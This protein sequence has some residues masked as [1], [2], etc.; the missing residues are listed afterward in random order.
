MVARGTGQNPICYS[1]QWR[2]LLK[3][4][5]WRKWLFCQVINGMGRI[6]W[7]K[8]CP[9]L[10]QPNLASIGKSEQRVK[11]YCSDQSGIGR[12]SLLFVFFKDLTDLSH[13]LWRSRQPMIMGVLASCY[14]NVRGLDT[15]VGLIEV[16]RLI[17][18]SYIRPL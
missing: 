1:A 13:S 15:G 10:G 14:G 4:R 7:K 2:R 6:E 5:L 3:F 16:A 18:F 8:G 9:V 11:G 17:A 12:P